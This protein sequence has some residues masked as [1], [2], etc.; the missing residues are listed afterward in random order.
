PGRR[1]GSRRSSALLLPQIR[2]PDLDERPDPL[3]EPGLAREGERLFPALPRL[4]RIDALLE[5]VVAR[6]E[7]LLDPLLDAISHTAT[8]TARMVGCP[9]APRSPSRSAC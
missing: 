6:H 1:G 8:L 4:L 3:L 5:P 9:P 2:D 7:Q